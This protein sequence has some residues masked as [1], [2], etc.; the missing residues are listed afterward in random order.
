MNKI[1]KTT[2]NSAFTSEA[3]F[4]AALIDELKNKG[5]E[6]EVLKTGCTVIKNNSPF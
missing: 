1:S 2:S 6:S 5:W 4:E 3:T